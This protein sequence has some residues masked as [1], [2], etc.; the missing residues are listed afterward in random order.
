MSCV[1]PYMQVVEVAAALPGLR[2]PLGVLV[3]PNPLAQQTIFG[4][5]S[6]LCHGRRPN[7]LEGLGD[8]RPF[9]RISAD[10]V[11]MGVHAGP[12]HLPG[13]LF[14]VSIGLQSV[15]RSGERRGAW[16]W[17]DQ[18]GADLH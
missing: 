14:V 13:D 6:T 15:D 17:R 5:L 8:Q 3:Q 9:H 4:D 2:E 18:S 10:P 7:Q 12:D 1:C 11:G 16:S